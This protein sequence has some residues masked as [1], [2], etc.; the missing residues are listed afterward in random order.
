MHLL[1]LDCAHFRR[2]EMIQLQSTTSTSVKKK[3]KKYSKP[4]FHM[5]LLN[6]LPVHRERLAYVRLKITLKVIFCSQ[7]EIGAL[8]LPES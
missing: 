7:I 1:S 4:Y 6:L 8:S 3:K 5:F 2:V